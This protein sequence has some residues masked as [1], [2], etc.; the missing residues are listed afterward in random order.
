MRKYRLK[1]YELQKK[2]DGLSNDLRYSDA[3]QKECEQ[4]MLSTSDFIV[5]SFGQDLCEGQYE[6]MYVCPKSDIV[7]YEDEIQ[8]EEQTNSKQFGRNFWR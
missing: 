8:I 4:Y 5:V 1:N 7:E 2:L 6:L 3:L